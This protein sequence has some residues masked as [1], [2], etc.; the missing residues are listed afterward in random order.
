MND[1]L[2]GKT[3]WNPRFELFAK[4]HGRTPM[5]QYSF[6]SFDNGGSGHMQFS[7]WIKRMWREFRAPCGH[8]DG[9]YGN[10]MRA[11]FGFPEVSKLY[12][13]VCHNHE[14]FDLWLSAGVED[15]S[16]VARDELSD[17]WSKVIDHVG[18]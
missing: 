14:I 13:C 2:P 9:A 7:F 8:D 16:I 6:D 11:R 1:V 5:E 3:G 4:L 10:A 12:S 18:G 17:F 15:G